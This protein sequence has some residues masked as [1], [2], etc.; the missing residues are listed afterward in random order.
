MTA[1][2]VSGGRGLSTEFI[3]P[4]DTLLTPDIFSTLTTA[5][6]G[7][8]LANAMLTGLLYRTGPAG[9]Y[10]D[11]FDTA[12]N[13]LTAL[14]GNLPNG[15][16][17]PGLSFKL[18]HINSVAFIGT[19]NSPASGGFQNG[20]NYV[21]GTTTVPASSWRDFLFTF[22]SVQLPIVNICSTINGSPNVLWTLAPGQVS[23]L[24]GPSALAVNIMP[25]CSV[26]GTGIPASTTVLGVTQG[27]GGTLGITLSANAT[28]TNAAVALT[29]GPTLVVG[30][31]GSGT[32]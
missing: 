5:G 9:A 21:S 8:I 30:S 26:T 29:F 14:A 17:V 31:P 22:T 10:A 12:A 19:F 23:E 20:S 2:R 32:L 15:P 11:T 7:S 28:A 6:A 1:I 16:I 18:R 3:N 24:Q 27:Q 13:I 25:G 4:G